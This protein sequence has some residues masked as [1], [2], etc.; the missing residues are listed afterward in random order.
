MAVCGESPD[1]VIS[2]NNAYEGRRRSFDLR[3]G[4]DR[5]VVGD[6][7]DVYVD[8]A[9]PDQSRLRPAWK[10][11][12]LLSLGYAFMMLIPAMFLAM[13]FEPARRVLEHILGAD[14]VPWRW[15]ICARD[16]S[17]CSRH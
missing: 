8:A 7:I 6:S 15:G 16:C 11:S 9:T 5:L 2:G 4:F 14:G 3:D 17:S 1:A 13:S 12:N 10:G